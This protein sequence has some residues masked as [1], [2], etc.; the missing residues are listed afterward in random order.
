M[1]RALSRVLSQRHPSI[2][3]QA[4]ENLSTEAA[5]PEPH[6]DPEVGKSKT[7]VSKRCIAVTLATLGA[8]V[9]VIIIIAVASSKKGKKNN[10]VDAFDSPPTPFISSPTSPRTNITRR[11][12]SPPPPRILSKYGQGLDL[13][14]QFY[15]I[16][17]SGK[18]PADNPIPWRGD[19]F[20]D[21]A[22][23]YNLTGG[24]NDAGDTLKFT[25]PMAWSMTVM[26]WAISAYETSFKTTG[27]LDHAHANLKWG[28]DYLL[29]LWVTG[30]NCTVGPC[31]VTLVGLPEYEHKFCWY[32]PEE[33]KYDRPVYA[34]EVGKGI[35]IVM[36]VAAA[37]AAS[38][39]VFAVKDPA[40]SKKLLERA[41]EMY[42]AAFTSPTKGVYSTKTTGVIEAGATYPSTSYD[43]E[44]QW[45][46]AWMY[47]ATQNSTYLVNA[48][49]QKFL[50]EFE[51]IQT[52][53][54]WD[55]KRFGAGVLLATITG[56]DYE[57]NKRAINSL[58]KAVTDV[59]CQ[60]VH[61]SSLILPENWTPGGLLF[62][63]EWGPLQYAGGAAFLADIYAGF[64]NGTTFVCGSK[65][66][67]AK[68]LNDFA[69]SQVDYIMGNNPL[70]FS[71]IVGYGDKYPRQLHHRSSSIPYNE[72]TIEI[73]AKEDKNRF[74]WLKKNESNP[75][76]P[77]GAVT[78]GP[79]K[80]DTYTDLREWYETGEPA[81]STNAPVL[82]A[83]A[84]LIASG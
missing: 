74:F 55:N 15:D 1:E 14:L 13:A 42:N 48:L 25:L 33:L 16:Q 10:D 78:G 71:Y 60:L 39:K 84:S 79:T 9:L 69:K 77:Y 58:R 83:M 52:Y 21:D 49:T 40:Y 19:S 27:T 51:T 61:G 3:G 12:P 68:D 4:Y 5:V 32:K 66:F 11:S 75:N 81:I 36:E 41:T 50:N 53:F 73:C 31:V 72:S 57:L 2:R 43:D 45:A 34:V 23:G 80:T 35:D 59:L 8:V 22:G 37:L 26:A 76:I 56:S 30:G 18:L 20:L 70:N 28:T 54:S 46:S 17:K 82:A 44:M 29:K 67:G 24:Y 7:I 38:S 6:V 65:T 63:E 62:L 64:T 47:M